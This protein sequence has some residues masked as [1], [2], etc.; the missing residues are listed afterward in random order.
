MTSSVWTA[1]VVLLWVITIINWMSIDRQT[2]KIE[3]RLKNLEEK[4]NEAPV[5]VLVSLQ[6]P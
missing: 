6:P 5:S 3:S 1:S 2:R 4:L